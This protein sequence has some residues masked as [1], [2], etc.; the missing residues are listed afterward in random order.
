MP[1]YRN[2]EIAGAPC[3]ECRRGLLGSSL[4]CTDCSEGAHLICSGLPL[5]ALICLATTR[6]PFVCSACTK[7]KA[8]E[9]LADVTEEIEGILEQE[10]AARHK[11]TQTDGSRMA[12]LGRTCSDGTSTASS[13]LQPPTS[14][15]QGKS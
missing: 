5:V 10:R 11:L 12:D 13:S 14:N 3:T 7:S 2:T 6:A 15:L 9:K 1:S 8:G 4:R